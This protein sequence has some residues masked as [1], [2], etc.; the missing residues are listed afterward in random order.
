MATSTIEQLV[1]TLSVSGDQAL[2]T[3]GAVERRDLPTSINYFDEAQELE[4]VA[5]AKEAEANGAE[6]QPKPKV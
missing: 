5:K 1:S 2:E 4:N 3:S 6:E